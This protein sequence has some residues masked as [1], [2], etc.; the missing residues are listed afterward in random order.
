MTDPAEGLELL[1]RN[2]YDAVLMDVS[3]PGLSGLT[4]CE[5][6]RQLPL[7]KRTPIIFVTGL[8]DFNTY[9][10]AILSGGNDLITKPILPN[11]LCVKVMTHLL[12]PR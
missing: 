2:P 5:Q 7:H 1:K 9:A 12:K 3:M 6:T 4:L 11:E 10:Q 8:G